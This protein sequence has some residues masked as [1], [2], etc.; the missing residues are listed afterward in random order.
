MMQWWGIIV[1]SVSHKNAQQMRFSI[2]LK[3]QCLIHFF[4]IRSLVVRSVS[5]EAFPTVQTEFNSAHFTESS[6]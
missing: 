2:L 3:K 4:Y 6:H 5:Y 1:V